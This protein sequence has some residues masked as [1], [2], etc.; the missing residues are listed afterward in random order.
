MN[1]RRTEKAAGEAL[2]PS[3]VLTG[4]SSAPAVGLRAGTRWFRIV[5]QAA[6]SMETCTMLSPSRRRLLNPIRQ[7]ANRNPRKKT[8]ARLRL[9]LLEPRLVLSPYVVTTTADSGPGSLRDAINQVNQD[10]VGL[11]ANAQGIDEIDFNIT[12]TS[13][14][15]GGFN[16]TTGAA[17]I[18][19]QSALPTVTNPVFINGFSQTGS[20]P[21]TLTNQGGGLGDN[22]VRKITL[23]GTSS[24]GD[25]LLISG[26]NSIVEGLT[27]QNFNVGIHL[28]TYGSDTIRG[29]NILGTSNDGIYVED[30]ANNTIGGTTPDAR[31]V[32]TNIGRR[33]VHLREGGNSRVQGTYINSLDAGIWIH[34]SSSNMIGGPDPSAGNVIQSY[35]AAVAV[36][37][38]LAP[39]VA[40]NNVIQA[41]F[42]DTDAAG[43]TAFYDGYSGVEIDGSLCHSNQILDNLVAISALYDRGAT[44]TIMRNNTIFGSAPGSPFARPGGG[45][46]IGVN[47][48][49]SAA[50]IEQNT[51]QYNGVGISMIAGAGATIRDNTI[52][53]NQ[54]DAGAF[55]ESGGIVIAPTYPPQSGPSPTPVTIEDNSIHDN[56]GPGVW[57]EADWVPGQ[58]PAD[59]VFGGFAET[60]ATGVEIGAN[61]SVYENTGL[62]IQ[63]GG[64]VVDANDNPTTDPN[65]WDHTDP[66][67]IIPNDYASHAT[68][69]NHWQNYPVLTDAQLGSSLEV[70]GTLHSP[71]GSSFTVNLY[72]TPASRTSSGR[73][74]EYWLGSLQ[75]GAN[76][77]FSFATSNLADVQSG[78]ESIT[79]TATNNDTGD[80]SEFSAPLILVQGGSGNNAIQIAQGGPS[81]DPSS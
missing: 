42:I 47:V 63:L 81:H 9:E 21:N 13:D 41:N 19:P 17:T 54:G 58:G 60:Y 11:Y 75:T 39:V 67:G 33:G 76:G 43:T 71:V 23:D 46:E 15:G 57:V 38:N 45:G 50:V 25:G 53:F 30:V 3:E 2:P 28:T 40:D 18:Q 14:T 52:A 1:S 36:S 66:L 55:S 65:A 16:A 32:L 70:T 12:A 5:P 34:S 10:S 56:T 68:G 51:I 29:V 26:G 78:V 27:I 69:P 22:A 20:S 37:S 24:G 48:S 61:N 6:C 4:L 80:T 74:G 62:G 8:L 79:A 77:T 7:R 44:G 49:G 72:A 64:V 31:N 35:G 59:G 73:Q